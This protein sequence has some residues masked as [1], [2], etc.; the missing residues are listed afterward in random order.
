MCGITLGRDTLELV[1]AGAA[2]VALGTILFADPGAPARIRAEL[3]S[4]IANLGVGEI[5]NAIGLAHAEP[6]A[7]SKT[8]GRAAAMSVQ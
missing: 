5:D 7:I 3:A 4:E 6:A 1:A 2:S 8:A